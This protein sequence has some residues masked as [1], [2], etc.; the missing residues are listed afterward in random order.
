MLISAGL[1][2]VTVQA[3]AEA[4]AYRGLHP[5]DLD[6]SWHDE[7]DIHAHDDLPVG[8]GPFGDVDGA[9]VFLGDPT[10]YGFAGPVYTYL[11][12]HP[13]PAEIGDRCGLLG[14]HRH[15]FAPEG[16]YEQRDG[17]YRYTGALRGSSRTIVPS[18]TQPSARVLRARSRDTPERPPTVVQPPLYPYPVPWV[19]VRPAP[20]PRPPPVS[21][22]P[23]SPRPERVRRPNRGR[24]RRY[25]PRRRR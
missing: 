3:A 9:L 10:A 14:E 22:A 18:V 21:V 23:P 24:Y 8:L 16:Q 1:S 2:L 17:N 5:I 6:G 19:V 20:R 12:V 11:G 13:L 4:R 15:H 25:L 7:T